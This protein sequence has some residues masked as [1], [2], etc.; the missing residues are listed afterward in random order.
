MVLGT[1]CD[2]RTLH[3]ARQRRVALRRSSIAVTCSLLV[4]FVFHLD[5]VSAQPTTCD[6][7]KSPVAA[8]IIEQVT[9]IDATLASLQKL[10]SDARTA[11]AEMEQALSKG[12]DET[13]L[14]EQEYVMQVREREIA[15][16]LA[17]LEV[18]KQRLC[19]AASI[20]PQ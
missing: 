18:L 4:L 10:L 15:R 5:S 17:E 9:K 11:R 7:G 8:S 1:C 2:H 6:L 12:G 16:Q 19:A 20:L 14:S 3:G 13:V